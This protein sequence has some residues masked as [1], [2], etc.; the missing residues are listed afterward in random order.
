MSIDF[1]GMKAELLCAFVTIPYNPN[2]IHDVYVFIGVLDSE[3]YDRYEIGVNITSPWDSR[4]IYRYEL[5][6]R[7]LICTISILPA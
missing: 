4:F 7:Y 6:L 5:Y 3:F 1:T 2:T